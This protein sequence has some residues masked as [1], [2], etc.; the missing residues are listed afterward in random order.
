MTYFQN[1]GLGKSTFG[2]LG[3]IEFGILVSENWL[4]YFWLSGKWIRDI[5]V[6]DWRNTLSLQQFL[7]RILARNGWKCNT[8]ISIWY[9]LYLK[10]GRYLQYIFIK[11]LFFIFSTFPPIFAQLVS[12]SRT[13]KMD[14]S[15]I[16]A[17]IY[18]F[19]RMEAHRLLVNNYVQVL[20]WEGGG[21]MT[22][23]ASVGY[24]IDH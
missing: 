11:K 8:C 24:K 17:H 6:C 22:V 1:F 3:K 21:K 19:E 16:D 20:L 10:D 13:D 9:Q 15:I 18:L 4:W 23:Y 12:T 7:S 14:P 2:I 5:I